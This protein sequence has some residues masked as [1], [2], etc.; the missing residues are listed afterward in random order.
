MSSLQWSRVNGTV[1]GVLALHA[2]IYVT[3]VACVVRSGAIQ[4]NLRY[5]HNSTQ[6]DIMLRTL[7]RLLCTA[8]V[9][10]FLCA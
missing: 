8:A 1:A 3:V 7:Q 10:L 2:F 9:S 6:G 4:P 5:G